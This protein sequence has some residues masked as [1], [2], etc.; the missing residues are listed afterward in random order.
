[1]E[2]HHLAGRHNSEITVLIPANDHRIL[3]DAQCDWGDETLRNPDR[4]PLLKAAA[5]LRGWLD[6]LTL[7]IERTVGWIPAFLE[8]LDAALRREHGDHWWHVLGWEGPEL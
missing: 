4:S 5:A 1:M 6:V 7:I 3:S 8:W 2:A